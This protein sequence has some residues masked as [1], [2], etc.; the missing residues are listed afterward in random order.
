MIVF[1]QGKFEAI[2]GRIKRNGSGAS[3]SIQAMNSLAFDTGE[4][5][6][7]IKSTYDA[8]VARSDDKLPP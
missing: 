6:G 7:V 3:R 1:Q 8:M 2:L 5:D 4:V